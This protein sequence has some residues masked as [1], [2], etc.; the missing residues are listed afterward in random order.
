MNEVI[1]P[2]AVYEVERLGRQGQ[3]KVHV[4]ERGR[5]PYALG[6]YF[7]EASIDAAIIHHG[8]RASAFRQDGA[9]YRR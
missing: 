9:R 8:S 1:E 7:D 5:V 4:I 2:T 3:L 6:V